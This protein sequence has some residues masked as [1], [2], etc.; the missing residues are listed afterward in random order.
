[1]A[2]PR[3]KR[4]RRNGSGS[5][6]EPNAEPR[7]LIL[8]IRFVMVTHS[9]G[10]VNNRVNARSVDPLNSRAAQ[11]GSG[12]CESSVGHHGIEKI[13][14]KMNTKDPKDKRFV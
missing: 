13:A 8:K 7:D 9:R 2:R 6:A 1:M 11:V 4:R 10:Y 3:A 5:Y 14:T 12:F